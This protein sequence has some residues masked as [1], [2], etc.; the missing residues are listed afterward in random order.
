MLAN[1]RVRAAPKNSYYRLDGSDPR[2]SDGELLVL[3]WESRAPKS[4]VILLEIGP[5]PPEAQSRRISVRAEDIKGIG[6][7]GPV[8]LNPATGLAPGDIR[9]M[10]RSLVICLTHASEVR[11][12]AKTHPLTVCLGP[13]PGLVK[14]VPSS[15]KRNRKL[16]LPSW[17]LLLVKQASLL[18]FCGLVWYEKLWERVYYSISNDRRV[19]H[20]GS[21]TILCFSRNRA[22]P[23]VVRSGVSYIRWEKA[24]P[25]QGPC[26]VNPLR[27]VVR[28]RK[29]VPAKLSGRGW[30][31]RRTST[32]LLGSCMDMQEGVLLGNG[33]KGEIKRK[34]YP[35]R[36]GR[37]LVSYRGTTDLQIS[38]TTKFCE[39]RQ[40]FLWIASFASFAV[41]VPMVPVHIWLPEA[42][43]EAPTAGSVILAGIPL[44][45]G[46]HGAI[47]IIYTSLTT[48]RQIDLKKIIAYSS[49]AHMNLVTIGMFSRAAAVSMSQQKLDSRHQQ[50]TAV[51]SLQ[52][53]SAPGREWGGRS[54]DGNSSTGS[55]KSESNLSVGFPNSFVNQN[56]RAR[57]ARF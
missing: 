29:V 2:E 25:L 21:S 15:K 12:A 6:K 30:V 26:A 34:L 53:L 39:R 22:N 1:L 36:D 9:S 32:R 56:Q 57:S 41:K 49:V 48:S 17:L 42:H 11:G 52:S 10:V 33:Y 37:K 24:F 16:A 20:A 54:L 35:T 38:L 14:S 8:S 44:K 23:Y 31:P 19:P 46:T 55:T 3:E 28:R 51:C 50:N 43:V 5:G 45:F 47:A 27:A 40:I 7:N 13:L 4:R 18:A